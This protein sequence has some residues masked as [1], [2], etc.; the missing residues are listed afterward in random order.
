MLQNRLAKQ[1]LYPPLT[2]TLRSPLFTNQDVTPNRYMNP[3]QMARPRNRIRT[4]KMNDLHIRPLGT[5]Q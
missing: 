2:L 4:A 1:N 3:N 5:A